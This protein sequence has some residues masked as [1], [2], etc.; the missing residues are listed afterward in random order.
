M[1]Q[2][3]LYRFRTFIENYEYEHDVKLVDVRQYYN[4]KLN[5]HA[6]PDAADTDTMVVVFDIDNATDKLHRFWGGAHDVDLDKEMIHM[7]DNSAYFEDP[8]IHH[9]YNHMLVHFDIAKKVQELLRNAQHE[10]IHNIV[11]QYTPYAA[12][13]HIDLTK[14][15]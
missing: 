5:K 1:S 3:D 15:K 8:D 10:K 14:Y 2:K 4:D 12:D 7:R 11:H 9:V 13:I 6:T